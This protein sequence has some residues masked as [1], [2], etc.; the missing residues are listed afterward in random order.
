MH[1]KLSAS[2]TALDSAR[3]ADKDDNAPRGET[4]KSVRKASEEAE[5]GERR[6]SAGP[7]PCHCLRAKRHDGVSDTTDPSNAAVL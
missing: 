2:G 1:D 3:A 7:S 6:A 4:L 5:E